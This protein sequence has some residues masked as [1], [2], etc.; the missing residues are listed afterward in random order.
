[1]EF[2]NESNFLNLD[3]TTRERERIAKTANDI[4]R[5]RGTVVS[6]STGGYWLE[7][8]RWP[9][10]SALTHT[11]LLINI[12][13]IKRESADEIL[14]RLVRAP[15]IFIQ[16]FGVSEYECVKAVLERK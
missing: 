16:T 11:A 5:E 15:N 14:A 1:M 13:L 2:F 12:E 6:R 4:L 3:H 9:E 7:S 10:R 8:G